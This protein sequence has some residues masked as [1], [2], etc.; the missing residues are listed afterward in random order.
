MDKPQGTAPGARTLFWI[1]LGLLTLGRLC[2]I[3]CFEF[4]TDEAHYVLYGR[5]L[6]WGYFDHPPMVGFLAA[7]AAL[8]GGTEFVM[9]LGPVLCGTAAMAFMGLLARDLYGWRTA[10]LALA[11]AACVPILMLLGVALLPDAPLNLFW[12]AALWAAWRATQR[13]GWGWWLLTGALTGGAMLSK[14]HGVLLPAF[15][16]LYILTSREGRRWLWRPQPYAAGAMALLVFLPNI[17]W[18]ARHDWASYAY[19]LGHGGG[20]GH[21]TLWNVFASVG[22]QLAAGTPILFVLLA[23][24]AIALFRNPRSEADRFVFWT[25]LP[26]FVF[27]CGI[28]LSGKV[29][30]HW[31]APGW[32]TGLIALAAILSRRLPEGGPAALRW[33]RWTL[34]GVFLGLAANALLPLALLFPVVGWTYSRIQPLSESLHARWSAVKALKPFEP[35][36]DISNDVVG[37]RAV[38][39]EVAALRQSQPRPD[40]TFVMAGRFFALSQTAA[41]LDPAIPVWAT[42]PPVNQ[43]NF[44][45]DP[46]AH[47][48]WD[49]I[50]IADSRWSRGADEVLP[51]FESVAPAPRSVSVDRFG[52]P[53]RR[54]RFWVCRGFKGEAPAGR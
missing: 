46:K 38:A 39:A 43:Y 32:W 41:Y 42:R 4:S 11:L 52:Y 20:K 34:A 33:K 28:G 53:A 50:F 48:G 25:S 23:A 12:C 3:G 17:V 27:F 36:F 7:L 2:L 22:G 21:V 35:R 5:H 45:F 13:G 1:L 40:R 18:N 16:G 10:L 9:R 51:L 31:P 37:W 54:T 14:Y 8:F 29:L 6:A 19:Q 15:L 44:W 49:A 26:V 47:Q 30:P 24:A